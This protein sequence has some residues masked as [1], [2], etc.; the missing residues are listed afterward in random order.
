[1]QENRRIGPM[2]FSRL[3]QMARQGTLATETPVRKGESGTWINAGTVDGIFFA[4]PAVAAT[5]SVQDSPEPQP[6]GVLANLA[7]SVQDRV[8]TTFSGVI[9]AMAGQLRFVRVVLSWIALIAVAAGLVVILIRNFPQFWFRAGD[10]LETYTSLWNEL[11][12]KRASKVNSAEW[13]AFAARARGELSPI[14]VRLERVASADNRVAQQLLWAGRDYFPKMLD[15]ARS[16]V[17]ASEQKFDYHLVRA[18]WLTEGKDLEGKPEY[19]PPL[20]A[21]PAN[22]GTLVLVTVFVVADLWIVVW[23]VRKKLSNRNAA[24]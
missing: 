16:S 22:T 5:V 3:R 2:T 13:D 11:R 10:P 21:L 18:R 24:S 4:T 12:E 14:V 19:R 7:I 1:M 15:D 23:F 8:Q 6:P 9:D 17:S 20:S